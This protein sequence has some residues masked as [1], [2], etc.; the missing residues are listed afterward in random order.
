MEEKTTRAV[1]MKYFESKGM[2]PIQ[3]KGAGPDI[4]ID[5]MAIEVKGS[6]HK[7]K[8]MLRQVLSYTYKYSKVAL[9][10]PVNGLTYDELAQLQKLCKM[11]YVIGK[12]D[13]ELYIIASSAKNAKTFYVYNLS[14]G[15]Y[16]C[17]FAWVIMPPDVVLNAEDS[18]ETALKKF[19]PLVNWKSTELII[20][21]FQIPWHGATTI[22]I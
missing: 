21:R 12:R 2:K 4:L 19:E 22:K 14:L 20:K 7:V 17:N 13:F 1:M 11:L 18:L 15:M 3:Q 9:A 8:R 6:G 5:G 16:P 10:L